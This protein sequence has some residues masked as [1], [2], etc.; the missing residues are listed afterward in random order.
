VPCRNPGTPAVC[1]EDSALIDPSHDSYDCNYSGLQT[2]E[3]DP[4]QIIDMGLE[5][6]CACNYIM[7]L[8]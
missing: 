8:S 1:C 5:V 7:W 6:Y 3:S 4:A 2:I